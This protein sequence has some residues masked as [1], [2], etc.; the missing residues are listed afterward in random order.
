M[1]EHV[2]AVQESNKRQ[3][4]FIKCYHTYLCKN[5]NGAK[6][7]WTCRFSSRVSGFIIQQLYLLQ[8]P[9]TSGNYVRDDLQRASHCCD[10]NPDR[11]MEDPDAVNGPI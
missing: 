11:E 2:Q 6:E 4:H 8:F 10:I 5:V 3:M 1:D 7:V 9:L